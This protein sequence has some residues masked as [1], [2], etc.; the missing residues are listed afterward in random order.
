MSLHHMMTPVTYHLTNNGCP[1]RYLNYRPILDDQHCH[2]LELDYMLTM[3]LR[4][5]DRTHDNLLDCRS[6]SS[7]CADDCGVAR[8]EIMLCLVFVSAPP[9]HCDVSH[10]TVGVSL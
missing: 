8:G 7:S 9:P 4:R 1:S 6:N 10:V 5:V 2:G 3:L